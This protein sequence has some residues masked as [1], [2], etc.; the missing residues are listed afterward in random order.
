MAF[1]TDASPTPARV[2]PAVDPVKLRDEIHRLSQRL[3]RARESY[4]QD[5]RS[6]DAE[7]PLE[8]QLAG[9]ESYVARLESLNEQLRQQGHELPAADLR[10][11]PAPVVAP[12]LPQPARHEAPP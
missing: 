2:Q 11:Q 8:V 6:R 10:E 1:S 5:L 9:I 4:D 12:L 7:V 3:L